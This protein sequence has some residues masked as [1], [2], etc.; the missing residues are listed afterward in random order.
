MVIFNS[1]VKLPEG[2]QKNIE[3]WLRETA[4]RS[5]GSLLALTWND[6]PPALGPKGL[7][8][9]RVSFWVEKKLQNYGKTMEKAT[10]T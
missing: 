2:T 5:P 9:V 10:E 7:G 8:C 4:A 3:K 1:Y 6:W